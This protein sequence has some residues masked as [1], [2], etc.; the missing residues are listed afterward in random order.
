MLQ[1]VTAMETRLA[2]ALQELGRQTELH[3][4][5]EQREQQLQNKM[6]ILESELLTAGVSKDEQ[7]HEKQQVSS[8]RC[9]VSTTLYL[10][11]SVVVFLAILNCG[12]SSYFST[13]AE[14]TFNSSPL[15]L[16]V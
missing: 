11:T 12:L 9:N 7:S 10:S 3:R 15:N 2:T 16:V 5:A 4:A 14:V 13:G 6:Q 1:S 8:H